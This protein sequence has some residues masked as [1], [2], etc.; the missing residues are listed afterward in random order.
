MYIKYKGINKEEDLVTIFGSLG[1]IGSALVASLRGSDINLLCVNRE[2]WDDVV[3]SGEDLGVV[4]WCV[5]KT[6][7]FRSDIS[8]T[9]Q[10]HIS[11]L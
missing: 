10:A 7:N 1:Y 3:Q 9:I 2:N 5:G 4:V 6:G 8:G 11:Q